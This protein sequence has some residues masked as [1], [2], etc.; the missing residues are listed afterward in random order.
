MFEH[1]KKVD[2]RYDALARDAATEEQAKEQLTVQDKEQ[3]PVRKE[4]EDQECDDVTMQED[5]Q[6]P[7]QSDVDQVEPE[8]MTGRNQ[9][10]GRQRGDPNT[11]EVEPDA[12][13]EGMSCSL[14]QFDFPCSA[15]FF[16]LHISCVSICSQLD[17]IFVS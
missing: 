1:I 13:M 9:K 17:L 2:Q 14:F 7:D 4:E 5:K 10:K 11:E 8:R 3:D 12:K 15:G 6:E 16:V